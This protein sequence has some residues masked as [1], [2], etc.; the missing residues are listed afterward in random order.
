MEKFI[1]YIQQFGNLNKQQI[2]LIINKAA[3]LELHKE[4]FYWEAGKT[5]K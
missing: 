1:D 3:E 2:D 5:V 4:D